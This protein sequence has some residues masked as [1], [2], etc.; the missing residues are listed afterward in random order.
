MFNT[1]GDPIITVRLVTV[2]NDWRQKWKKT[3]KDRYGD[4]ITED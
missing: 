2:P 1:L 3:I 4:I